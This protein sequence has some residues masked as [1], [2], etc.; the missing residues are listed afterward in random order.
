MKIGQARHLLTVWKAF[1]NVQMNMYQ[2]TPPTL[3]WAT[4][5]AAAAAAVAAA[6]PP[7]PPTTTIAA[8]AVPSPRVVKTER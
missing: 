3:S 8:A 7:P 4:T 1:V 5:T 2:V 6:A